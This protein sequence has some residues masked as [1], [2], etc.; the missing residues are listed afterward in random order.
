MSLTIFVCRPWDGY[1]RSLEA[2]CEQE[3]RVQELELDLE[4]DRELRWERPDIINPKTVP[5]EIV[6]EWDA[7]A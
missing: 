4:R 7:Y 5:A 6:L 2:L 3:G 1:M